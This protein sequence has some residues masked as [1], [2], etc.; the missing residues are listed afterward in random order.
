MVEYSKVNVKLSNLQLNKLKFAVKKQTGATL[1]MNFKM[2]D[3]EK[4]FHEL[5]LLKTRQKS[6]QISKIIQYN[7]FLGVLLSKIF[8]SLLKVAVSLAKNILVSLGITAAGSR[9]DAGVQKKTHASGM[10]TL[11]I[12]KGEINDIIKIG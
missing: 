4:L 2:L 9:I 10:T 3:E 5:F 12:A 8:V 7:E 6:P 1:R 11:I